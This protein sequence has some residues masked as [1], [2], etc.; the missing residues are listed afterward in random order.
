MHERRVLT[1]RGAHGQ[2]HGRAWAVVAF[3]ERRIEYVDHAIGVVADHQA[4]DV[5]EAV[6]EPDIHRA[7]RFVGVARAAAVEVGAAVRVHVVGA[8]AERRVVAVGTLGPE[9]IR[10]AGLGKRDAATQQRA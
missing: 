10:A 5:G 1:E 6:H 9:R 2:E 8:I 7:V 3:V 4:V